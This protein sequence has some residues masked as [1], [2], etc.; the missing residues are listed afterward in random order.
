LRDRTIEPE[1]VG[2]I[3][4]PGGAIDAGQ[5][6]DVGEVVGQE[7]AAYEWEIETGEQRNCR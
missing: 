5:M 2:P 7:T 6:N 1:G 4:Q 3:N